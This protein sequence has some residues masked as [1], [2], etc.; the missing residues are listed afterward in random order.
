MHG[1][2]GALAFIVPNAK[3]DIFWGNIFFAAKVSAKKSL[4]EVLVNASR[5]LTY[6]FIVA[7]YF[8]I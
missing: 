7:I 6:S 3:I 1:H 5:S 8:P 4:F 2:R